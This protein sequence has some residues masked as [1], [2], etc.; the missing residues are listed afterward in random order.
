MAVKELELLAAAS[1]IIHVVGFE[2]T[3]EVSVVKDLK[4]SYQHILKMREEEDRMAREA[5]EMARPW[6]SHALS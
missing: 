6:R 2:Q 1:N 5:R 3:K 4:A